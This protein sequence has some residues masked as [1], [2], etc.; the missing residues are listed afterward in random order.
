VALC[1]FGQVDD[2]ASISLRPP[3]ASYS[4]YDSMA[5][6]R[7]M[8]APGRLIQAASRATVHLSAPIAT[9]RVAAPV[10][11]AS[12]RTS[13]P[14]SLKLQPEANVEVRPVPR[15]WPDQG[16]SSFG[17]SR[18]YLFVLYG[19][20]WPRMP[21]RLSH[22]VHGCAMPDPLL[23]PGRARDMR[24]FSAAARACRAVPVLPGFGSAFMPTS[25]FFAAAPNSIGVVSYLRWTRPPFFVAAPCG[26]G[27]A[28][29]APH[30][31]A[32]SGETIHRR[33]SALHT[34]A[35][36]LRSARAVPSTLT[37]GA[38]LPLQGKRIKYF[39]IYRW[40]PDQSSAPTVATYPIDLAD[41]GAPDPRA[42]PP[43][44]PRAP[45]SQAWPLAVLD[46]KPGCVCTA[47]RG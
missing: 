11:A 14:N 41:C 3:K 31:R 32:A 22:R 26:R 27:S 39:Q 43:R 4:S 40:D 33:P 47:R 46:C 5:T 1:T 25:G 37:R 19:N 13:A 7:S 20:I 10:N 29:C 8:V 38:A 15:R 23:C 12:F 9:R 34:R 18:C 36:S 30:R 35:E 44:L 2:D 42:R 6:L 16:G 24:S 21:Q 17:S 45:L 28:S